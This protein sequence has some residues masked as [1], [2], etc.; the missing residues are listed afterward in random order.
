MRG[1]EENVKAMAVRAPMKATSGEAT[2]KPLSRMGSG[3]KIG[4]G[5]R[6]RWTV[7]RRLA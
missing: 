2:K 3:S 6:G 4:W 1:N 7:R 5:T